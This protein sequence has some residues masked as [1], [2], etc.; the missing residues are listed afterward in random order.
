MKIKFDG[1]IDLCIKDENQGNAGKQTI[2]KYL[3]A[4]KIAIKKDNFTEE[5]IKEFDDTVDEFY[6]LLISTAGKDGITN[7]LHVIGAGHLSCYMKKCKS[8]CRF[9]QQGWESLNDKI[10][11]MFFHHTQKGGGFNGDCKKTC[12]EAIARM[13]LRDALWRSGIATNC[14]LSLGQ[15]KC[16]SCDA[17]LLN[18]Y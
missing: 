9:C 8:L 15:T 6:D 3:D 13:L 16:R 7:Y 2:A 1:L 10:S 12:L 18:Y 5:D 17:G 11:C 14:V 4:E